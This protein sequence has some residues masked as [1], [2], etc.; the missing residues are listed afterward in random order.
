[1]ARYQS[2]DVWKQVFWAPAG[3]GR[4]AQDVG[5]GRV[6]GPSGVA[7]QEGRVSSG[8]TSCGDWLATPGAAAS[9]GCV[10]LSPWIVLLPT[11]GF[12]G[13]VGKVTVLAF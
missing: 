3:G 12:R 11:K 2:S 8:C 6:M 9:S 4:G 1:V 13:G 5:G 7:L 10:S